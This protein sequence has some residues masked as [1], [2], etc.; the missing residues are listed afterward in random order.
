MTTPPAEPAN[1]LSG[2]RILVAE[3]TMMV[4]MSLEDLLTLSG[5]HIIKAGSLSK[6]L[7]LGRTE[8]LDG[9]LLDINLRGERVYPVAAELD[10]RAIPFIF[11]TGY[12]TDHIEAPWRDRPVLE[13]PIDPDR[14]E[15]LVG[16][17]FAAS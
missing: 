8:T 5:C 3:D 11:L 14:L 10:R 17:T 16:A 7:D 13:K 9:A 6:A 12:S 2:L 1:I 15:S 4:A